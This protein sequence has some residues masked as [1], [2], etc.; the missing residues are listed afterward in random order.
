MK[1]IEIFRLNPNLSVPAP[2]PNNMEQSGIPIIFNH[3]GGPNDYLIAA[4]LQAKLTNPRSPVFVFHDWEQTPEDLTANGVH[5]IHVKMYYGEC[6]RLDE[7]WFNFSRN[8]SDYERWCMERW[9]ILRN[10]M[11][12]HNIEKVFAADSDVLIYSD[13]SAAHKNFEKCDFTVSHLTWGCV[14]INNIRV[15]DVIH[16]M[17][18][19]FY[20]RKTS[21]WWRV[22]DFLNILRPEA[23]VVGDL[24]DT[25]FIR[26]FTNEMAEK[27][28]F[29][30]LN[31]CTIIEDSAFCPDL[32]SK[33]IPCEM[34]A[35][36][37]D[38]RDNRP[39]RKIIWQNGIP[40]ARA[41]ETG[42]LVKMHCLHFQGTAKLRFQVPAFLAFI[43]HFNR[44]GGAGS[45]LEN[46]SGFHFPL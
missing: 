14:F 1:R 2:N 11:R 36:S 22:L 28:G 40:Y 31:T 6:A 29:T 24:A 3:R 4:A 8:G 7:I 44:S 26:I 43:Q 5:C 9:M 23:E 46:N 15:L 10:F 20:G 39:F 42:R 27:L 41:L 45:P 16:D 21:L 32:H 33:F 19:E 30:W 13:I 25:V 38:P 37:I 12:A 18:M 34:E 17:I 35:E